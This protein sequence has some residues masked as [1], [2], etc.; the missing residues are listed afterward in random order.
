MTAGTAFD[1]IVIGAG[2]AGASVAAELSPEAKVLLLEMESQPG[3][4]TTGRSAAVYTPIY[5]PQPIRA[6]TRASRAFFFDP[7]DGFADHPLLSKR[8]GM[9]VANA[10]QMAALEAAYA[11]MG[12]EGELEWLDPAGVRSHQPL[13]REDYV[14]GGFLDPGCFDIDV[15]ALHQGYL[16]RFK[17]AGG[18]IATRAEVTA[19]TRDNDIW[20]ITSVEGVFEAPIIVNAAGAWA[21]HIGRLA[22]AE[23]IGLIPKRRTALIVDAP[24]GLA[25]DDCPLVVGIEEDFYLKPDAG[26]LLLSPANED[27][28]V[29]CDVQP[30]EMD[31][32]ICIDRIEKAFDLQIRRIEN[33]WAGLRSFVA[34]KCPVAGY[35]E[36]T[37]GF[38]WLAGQGG[39][40][41][42]SA[43]A[44]SR[45]AASQIVG[46][47]IPQDVLTE[48][49]D[50]ATL[51][52]GRLKGIT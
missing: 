37:E 31:I 46:S 32:A 3:Y 26:R 40:G 22:G 29:P 23:E 38:Y 34:D 24:E 42:Q 33:R 18:R 30:D 48:G 16:S 27:P 36:Q 21:D 35:S 13:L 7:P 2:I 12:A 4:H 9:F 20:R 44:L 14:A 11:E 52:P 45:F 6:L 5:G 15:H 50:P 51:A 43:P 17:A 28:E 8:G 39:Y 41:I 49:L 1:I 47:D 19:M 25:L 10:D